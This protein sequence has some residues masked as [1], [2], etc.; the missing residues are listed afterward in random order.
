VSG[1][2][3][4]GTIAEGGGIFNNFGH[5][6]LDSSTVSGN[7][8]VGT[9]LAQGGGIFN[10]AGTIGTVTLVESIVSGNIPDNCVNV[11]GC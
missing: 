3:A 7:T 5:L 2:R 4:E 11:P 1:N 9:L 10:N 6:M 8:A